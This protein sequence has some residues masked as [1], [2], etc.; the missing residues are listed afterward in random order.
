MLNKIY[1]NI[2]DDKNEDSL[3]FKLRLNRISLLK[4]QLIIKDKPLKILDIGGTELFWKRMGLCD[5]K[6]FEITV[7][8]LLKEEEANCTNI[9]SRICDA[10]FMNEFKNNEFDIA[11][12]NS[13]IEHVGSYKD[14]KLM[15]NEIQRVGKNFFIQTPN[16]YFPIEPHVFFPFFQF[17]PMKVKL[18]MIR[19]FKLGFSKNTE[20]KEAEDVIKSLR[21]LKKSELKKLFPD[22]KIIEEKIYGIVYSFM[23]INSD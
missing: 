20:I 19:N 23:V 16:L 15:A 6:N 4:E 18:I 21:L 10:R 8:N 22:A 12:S 3:A 5:D 1:S 2:A 17:F 7:I 14:Q 9:R 11:F 13:V